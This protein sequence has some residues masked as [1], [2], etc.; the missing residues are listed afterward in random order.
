MG[1]TLDTVFTRFTPFFLFFAVFFLLAQSVAQAF[2]F[3]TH[4]YYRSRVVYYQDLDLQR[5]NS[6]INQGGLGDNNRFGPMLFT[7]QRLRLEPMMKLNDNISIHSSLD[8][9]DNVIAGTNDTKKIDFL[10]PIVGSIQLPGAGGALGVTG[11][12]A[13]ENKALNIR[14]AYV[15]ILTPGGKFRIGRQPSHFGLGVFQNDGNGLNDDFGDT[16]DRILYLASLETPNSGT[17]NFGLLADF[18]F[19]KQEDPRIKGLGGTL[20]NP[21][22]DMRQF[23]GLVL[24][25]YKDV[26]SLGTFS[27]IRYRKGVAGATTTTARSIMVDANGNP[28][29]DS[30]GNNQLGEPLPAGK[31]GDTFLSFTDV[32]GEFKN[33]PYRIRGEYVL[34][35][36]KLS[37]GI[38]LDA[39]PFNNLPANA[40]G[41]IELPSQND[42][43]IQMGAMEAEAN[44]NFGEFL[45][46]G[47]YASGDA[48]PLSSKITQFGF[49]PDYQIAQLLFHAPLGSSPRVSQGNGNGN[50]SRVL[51]GA[52]P[53]TGNYINNAIYVALAY[54]HHLDLS[55]LVPKSSDTKVGLKFITAWAPSSN[56][57]IDFQEM[58]GVTGLPRIVNQNRWYGW[59]VDADFQSRFWKNCFFNLAGGYLRPGSAYDVEVDVT[60]SPS[61]LPGINSIPFDKAEPAWVARS[62]LGVE[63]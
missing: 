40:R 42:A 4:G 21:P 53:V 3:A 45:L 37:T 54:H 36:G 61:N 43:L 27:G 38:A 56:F 50:G 28:I 46:Q 34:M 58:T 48:Q 14:R 30:N 24:Y 9:L 31:D 26:F 1:K 51:V 32:Y 17:V 39:I 8:V 10:S 57:D 35:L 59:E 6:N 2:D 47:G 55:T 49:R 7:Q 25:D 23:A 63:F 62:N 41:P 20:T 11:G 5:T 19:T 13:G 33:G 60:F 12:Q 44:Y 16:F 15:D 52:V 22:E 29:L 18:V